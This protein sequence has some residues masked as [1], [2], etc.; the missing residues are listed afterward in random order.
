M[1]DD[2]QTAPTHHAMAAATRSGLRAALLAAA[3]L[4]LPLTLAACG[5]QEANEQQVAQLDDKLSGADADPAVNEAMNSPI[6]VDPNLTDQSNRNALRDAN[7]GGTGAVP[8][9][10]GYQGDKATA[11]DLD[12]LKLM[13]APE[14]RVMKEEECKDCA[15]PRTLG[16]LAARQAARTGSC[17]GKLSY[18]AGWANRMPAAFPVYPKGRV[19]EAAGASGTACEI[20]VVSFVSA[21]P[22]REVVDYYYTRARG[23]GYD[24]E[25]VI[26][27]GDHAL[28]GTRGE[29]A[30]YITF[31]ERPGGGTAVDI[32]ANGGS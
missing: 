21:N 20:R 28:G 4:G 10:N 18:G 31:A 6:L 32:V 5:D 3:A 13:R 2:L 12:G 8:P 7:A 24:A 1:T 22:M 14:P 19:Q 15:K 17:D 29:N 16:T 9:D 26:R 11:A 25:Y 27:Q 23:A 30:Y